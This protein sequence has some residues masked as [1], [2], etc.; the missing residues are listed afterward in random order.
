MDGY[1]E[2]VYLLGHRAPPISGG[3]P[4]DGVSE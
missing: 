2:A 4:A 1:D 3:L